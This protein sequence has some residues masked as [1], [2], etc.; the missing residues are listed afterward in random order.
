MFIA[1]HYK[2]KTEITAFWSAHTYICYI[3]FSVMCR[4]YLRMLSQ[5]A[6]T[7]KWSKKKCQK[8]NEIRT[9]KYMD[10]IS[11]RPNTHIH[12]YTKHSGSC[13]GTQYRSYKNT[14]VLYRLGPDQRTIS[15]RSI[16][17]PLHGLTVLLRNVD[18][19]SDFIWNRL[20]HILFKWECVKF[21]PILV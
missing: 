8:V 15:Y 9:T 20:K 19:Y 5:N 3:F 13:C 17:G 18:I 6:Y 16:F 21:L 10:G 12:T 4:N 7:G 2:K 11:M 1:T 14:L